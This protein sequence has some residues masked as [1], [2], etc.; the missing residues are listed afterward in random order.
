MSKKTNKEI[1]QNIGKWFIAMLFFIGV[2]IYL[3]L[4]NPR[5]S[6]II[7]RLALVHADS[8]NEIIISSINLKSPYNLTK[9]E[10]K[11]S[12]KKRLQ[13]ITDVLNNIDEKFKHQPSP[14]TWDCYLTLNYKE[15]SNIVL[16][17]KETH[18]GIC[19]EFKTFPIEHFFANELKS[20]LENH[21][22][23][24]QLTE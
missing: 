17:V 12:D 14:K 2:F 18:Y 13:E 1:E 9:K 7:D 21:A 24:K 19:V 11:I 20:I 4:T 10:I 3:N 22:N 15:N 23:Y 16:G 8:L 6:E 5:P